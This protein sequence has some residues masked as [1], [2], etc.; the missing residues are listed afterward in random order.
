RHVGAMQSV[1]GQSQFDA[2]MAERIVG[3]VA[4]DNMIGFTVTLEMFL[5]DV[6]GYHPGRIAGLAADR[7][8]SD[9]RFP[10][11]TS[12]PDR[13]RVHHRWPDSARRV[14]LARDE[15][16][17]CD[18]ALAMEPSGRRREIIVQPDLGDV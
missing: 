9:R 4:V 2:V 5:V 13:K 8:I 7:K 1:L 18:L 16:G 12:Q 17:G 14:L 10:I 15:F 11:E 6:V 3:I